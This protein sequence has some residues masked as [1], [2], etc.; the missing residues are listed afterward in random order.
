MQIGFR[1]HDLGK[2]SSVTQLAQRA[3]Y[4]KKPVVLHLAL[5][6]V[7]IDA[8]DPSQYTSEYVQ[9]IH[10]DLAKYQVSIA[11]LGS[12]FNPIHP[13]ENIRALQIDRFINTLKF[14]RE[15]GCRLVGTETGSA[16]PDCSYSLDTFSSKNLDIFY[17]TVEKLLDAA[18]KY[19]GIVGLEAV[20][21]QHTICSIERMAAVM[22]KFPSEHLGVIYDPINLVPYTGISE[23]DGSVLPKPSDEAQKAFIEKALDAFGNRIK[24]VHVKDYRLDE[25]GLKIGDL[26]ANTGVMNWSLISK[27]LDKYHITV[28]CT[29]E[30]LQPATLSQTL[31]SLA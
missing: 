28:P 29:L 7:L 19:D 14:N 17:H 12:Y 10:D 16:N 21:R 6:K 25:N 13:N 9:S 23:S 11:I 22:E 26:T 1:A 4:F 18:V 2:F 5:G 20:S 24:V 30:D 3:A 31:A 27:E 8:K 15:F